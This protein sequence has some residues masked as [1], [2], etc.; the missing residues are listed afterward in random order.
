MKKIVFLF[1]LTRDL[2]F[3]GLKKALRFRRDDRSEF[4]EPQKILILGYAAIGDLIFFLPTIQA[5]RSA[6]PHSFIVFAANRYPTS[7][8]LIPATNLVNEVWFIEANESLSNKNKIAKKIKEARFDLVVLTPATPVRFFARGIFSI[9]IR[10]GHCRQI[11]APHEQWSF[12]RYAFWKLK[13]AIALEELER[14]LVLNRKILLSENKDHMVLQNLRLI[15]LLGLPIPPIDES[16]PK[17]PEPIHAQNEFQINLPAL[18]RKKKIGV[19]LGSAQS[20]YAKIWAAEKWGEV[21]LKIKEL[22]DVDVVLFGGAKE[23]EAVIKFKEVFLDPCVNFVGELS[24]LE[25]FSAIRHCILF[26]SSDTGLSK[27]AM[28]MSIPTATV[29][30]PVS[31]LEFG[32][33][34]NPENH[35]EL[36]NSVPCSPCVSLG[37]RREGSDV[38]NFDTCG[39]HRCLTEL[40]PDTVFRAINARYGGLMSS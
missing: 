35:L 29:W 37:I 30:G 11:V 28:A 10:V 1:D 9:P 27:A 32:V 39:H 33:I 34:W 18:S 2:F 40:S 38:I 16:R 6:F 15:E 7:E 23:K 25:T 4:K 3:L 17:I 31:R 12:L 20:Q 36:F 24:L 22:Y 13:R 26:L 21:C 5:L 8:E 19:H 14:R